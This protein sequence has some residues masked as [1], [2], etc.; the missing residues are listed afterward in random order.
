M[1]TGR[2]VLYLLTHGII[3]ALLTALLLAVIFLV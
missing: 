3:I 2:I 1:N